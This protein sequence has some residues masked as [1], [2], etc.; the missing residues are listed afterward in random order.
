MVKKFYLFA[1]ALLIGT[2]LYSAANGTFGASEAIILSVGTGGL[3][4]GFALWAVIANRDGS[5]T[6]S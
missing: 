6:A 2:G 3:V 1:W 4:Y 5:R